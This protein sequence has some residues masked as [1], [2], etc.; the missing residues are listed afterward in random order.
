MITDW[1]YK[2]FGACLSLNWAVCKL[3]L[4][5]ESVRHDYNSLFRLKHAEVLDLKDMQQFDTVYIK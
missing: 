1:L 2:T 5:N 4:C 3:P